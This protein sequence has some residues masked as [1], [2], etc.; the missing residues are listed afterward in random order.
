MKDKI[1]NRISLDDD[2]EDF[3]ESSKSYNDEFQDF[4]YEIRFYLSEII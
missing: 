2:R 3:P 4:L 1:K